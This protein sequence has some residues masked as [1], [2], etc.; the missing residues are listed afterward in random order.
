MR[1]RHAG[2]RQPTLAS[3]GAIAA[4]QRAARCAPADRWR[5]R[6]HVLVAAHEH[7]VLRLKKHPFPT[8]FSLFPA[9]SHSVST[10]PNTSSLRAHEAHTAWRLGARAAA[11]RRGG[12][13]RDRWFRDCCFA[14]AGFAT[15][16]FATGFATAGYSYL[17]RQRPRAI[18][19][20]MVALALEK[21]SL[22]R[23]SSLEAYGAGARRGCAQLA[24]GNAA[25]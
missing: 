9:F 17:F 5:W 10:H 2:P 6:W 22:D 21:S 25:R 16:G 20:S 3:S 13:F 19:R 18:A 8:P 14:T 23:P 15:A 11:A 4:R 12:P 24:K 1:S 7:V